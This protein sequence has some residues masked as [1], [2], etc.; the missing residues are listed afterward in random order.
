MKL[1]LD[2]TDTCV[3]SVVS[4]EINSNT[5][6]FKSDTMDW[7]KIE[8]HLFHYS[9]IIF[10]VELNLRLYESKVTVMPIS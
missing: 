5:E 4:S 2:M 10:K 3:L 1:R 9:I 8:S 6:V 7:S